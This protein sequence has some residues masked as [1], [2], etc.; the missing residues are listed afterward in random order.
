MDFMMKK[1]E[2]KIGIDLDGIYSH[3]DL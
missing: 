3:L 1:L 2:K